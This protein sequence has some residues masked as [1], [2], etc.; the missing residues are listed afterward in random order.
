MKCLIGILIQE[1]VLK[2]FFELKVAFSQ[3]QAAE[4]PE[5]KY[6]QPIKEF[7]DRTHQLSAK[8]LCHYSETQNFPNQ[9]NIILKTETPALF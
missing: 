5:N 7:A 6:R 2:Q 9:I 4:V 1:D 3:R 8:K